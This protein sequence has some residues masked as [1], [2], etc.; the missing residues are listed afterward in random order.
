MSKP[1]KGY[2]QKS[3]DGFIGVFSVGV[4]LILIGM[5]FA[6]TPDLFNKAVS[7]FQDF[8]L[9][10]VPNIS[11]GILLPAPKNPANHTTIYSTASWFSFAWGI[12]LVALLAL[13]ILAHSPLQ[14]K[15]EN[16]SDIFFWLTNGFL[17]GNYLN[18]TTTTVIWFT[19]WTLIIILLGVSL[20]IRAIILAAFHIMR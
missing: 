20:I 2:T 5:I 6:M 14:K 3:R 1:Y 7:F 13:R 12:F 18:N 9:V 16:A 15:A 17:I 8:D 10:Q 4:F 19:F 11:V